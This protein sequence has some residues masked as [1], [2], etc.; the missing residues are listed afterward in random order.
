MSLYLHQIHSNIYPASDN[1]NQK[2]V[3]S[4]ISDKTNSEILILHQKFYKLLVELK[5]NEFSDI[6]PEVEV[7]SYKLDDSVEIQKYIKKY[8]PS[9]N[10]TPNFHVISKDFEF[11]KLVK[12]INQIYDISKQIEGLFNNINN[13]ET[14]DDENLD[15][16]NLDGDEKPKSLISNISNHIKSLF[17]S[18]KDDSDNDSDNDSDTSSLW[19]EIKNE[20]NNINLI[21]KIN[22]NIGNTDLI[23]INGT[24][25]PIQMSQLQNTYDVEGFSF[26]RR[27]RGLNYAPYDSFGINYSDDN[28]ASLFYNEKI[29]PDTENI[30]NPNNHQI[31]MKREYNIIS[32]PNIM[33]FIYVSNS[34]WERKMLIMSNELSKI[35]LQNQSLFPE[36]TIGLTYSI[37]WDNEIAN[38]FNMKLNKIYS[39]EPDTIPNIIKSIKQFIRIDNIETKA[40]TNIDDSYK[41]IIDDYLSKSCYLSDNNLNFVS[42]DT[43]YNDIIQYA[44]AIKAGSHLYITKDIIF[45]QLSDIFELN[46]KNINHPIRNLVYTKISPFSNNPDYGLRIGINRDMSNNNLRNSNLQLRSDVPN[47]KINV[48]I[49]NQSTI[50]PVQQLNL[51]DN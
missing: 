7:V 36:I 21:N 19:E 41:Y 26:V 48:S 25:N 3:K 23:N 33:E 20:T 49:W 22:Q 34:L 6:I 42:L 46:S 9:H 45:N 30:E 16:E 40:G 12:Y 18:P 38:C 14:L 31:E 27:G 15:D 11:E 13:D 17:I 39:L 43:L 32:N 37:Q 5:L 29:I 50:E 4:I 10:K 44:M 2:I 24:V 47:P 1:H 28:Y 35:Y 8:L 51:F